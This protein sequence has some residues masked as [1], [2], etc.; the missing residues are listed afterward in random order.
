MELVRFSGELADPAVLPAG[1]L[2]NHRGV[3]VEEL[4]DGIEGSVPV[5]CT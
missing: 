5:E 3:T 2:S 4:V 1:E